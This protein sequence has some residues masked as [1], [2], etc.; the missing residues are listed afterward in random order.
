MCC[1]CITLVMVPA[2]CSAY[3]GSTI[4]ADGYTRYGVNQEAS[5]QRDLGAEE[6]GMGRVQDRVAVVTG[7]ANGLGQAIA[8]CLAEEGARLVLGDLDTG[9]LERT[10]AHITS[11]GGAVLSVVGSV[12]SSWH[13]RDTSARGSTG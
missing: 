8:C 11:T 13:G 6:R 3:S 1:F 4:L 12:T 5:A 10:A 2:S 9:E 7:G